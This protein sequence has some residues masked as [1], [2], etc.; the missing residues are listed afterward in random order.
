MFGVAGKYDFTME[1]YSQ[2]KFGGHFVAY[3]P[4]QLP[5]V[6]VL[7]SWLIPSTQA[8]SSMLIGCEA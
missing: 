2:T 6:Q 5:R 1:T 4:Q 8:T 3:D 7:A